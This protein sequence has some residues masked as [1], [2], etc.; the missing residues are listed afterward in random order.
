[1]LLK[2]CLLISLQEK[3]IIF[4]KNRIEPENHGH[5][6]QVSHSKA[7]VTPVKYESDIQQMASVFTISKIVKLTHCGLVTPYG[8]R[9]LGQHWLM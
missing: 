4:I 9:D 5:I 2:L 3:M 7:V 8:D 1:M 6:C